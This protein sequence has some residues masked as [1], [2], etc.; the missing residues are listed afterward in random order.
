MPKSLREISG[1]A[2]IDSQRFACIQ[3]EEGIIFIYNRVSNLIEK[4]TRFAKRGDF[5]GIAVKDHTAFVIRADGR[6][7]EINL[8]LGKKSVIKHK[9]HLTA[10]QDVEG[11]CYDRRNN[12]LLLAIKHDEPGNARFKGIY[13]FDLH[14]MNVQPNP[15]YKLDLQHA[16]FHPHEGKLNKTIR[17]SEIDIHPITNDLYVTDGPK[18]RLLIL[19][20]N[21]NIKKLFQLGKKF[22]QPEGLTFSPQGDIFISNEGKNKKANICQVQINLLRE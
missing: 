20:S 18:S 5:E 9:T 17:P 15:V 4:Q 8:L 16:I 19:D 3:D 14:T 12:R 11:L 6:L 21:G 13:A 10:K 1:L 22:H 2:Y 7:F